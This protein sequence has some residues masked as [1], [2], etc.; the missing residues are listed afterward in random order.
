MTQSRRILL[1]ITDLEIGGTPT[2]VRELAIRLRRPGVDTEVACLSPW[3]PVA[4]QLKNAGVRVTALG[5]RT[6]A[7]L[8]QVAR[9]T[10][11]IVRTGRFDIVFSFLTHANAVAAIAALFCPGVRFFQSIQ[12][13]QRTPRWH[14]WLAGVSQLAA[15]RIIVPS[16]S[17]ALC[18][19][20]WSLIAPE[21][22]VIISNAVDLEKSVMQHPKSDME[23]NSQVRIGFV[24]RLD[25][26][27]RIPDLIKSIG[28]L[29]ERF[30]LHVFG[31]GEQRKSIEQLIVDRGLSHRITLHGAVARPQGALE[32]IDVL[33][34]PSE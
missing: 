5:A 20:D 13:T 24:G 31:D 19:R 21:K 27:K 25:P 10:I 8:P 11:Q 32:R 26:V 16:E 14:W 2:V 30:V 15:E 33:V 28:Q 17:A 34:L 1:L 22:I 23:L 4:D 18:A 29:D 7:R 3:G 6:V 12:T 9:R